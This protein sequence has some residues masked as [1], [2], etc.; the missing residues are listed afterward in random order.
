MGLNLLLIAIGLVICFGGIYIRKVCSAFL[1][2]IWGALC[3]FAVILMSVGLWGIDE[4]SFYIVAVC[5]VVF[6]II[7]CIH[8]KLCAAINAFLSTFFLVAI[9]LLLAD[10]TEGTM[11]LLIA[12]IVALVVR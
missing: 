6:A 2:L 9:L 7:S 11:L 4:E 10:S 1:G 3:S 12:G 5:A 8:D